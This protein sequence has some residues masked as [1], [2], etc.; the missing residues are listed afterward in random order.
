MSVPT[1]SAPTAAAH[2][3]H[4]APPRLSVPADHLPRLREALQREVGSD[5]AARVLHQVGRDAGA[6]FEARL[7]SRLDASPGELSTDDYFRELSETF[8]EMGWGT[9][10]STRVHPGLCLIETSEWAEGD[11]NAPAREPSCHFT[12]GVFAALLAA[13]A[14][15]PIAVLEVACRTRGDDACAFLFGSEDAIR[16]LHTLLVEGAS[17]AEALERL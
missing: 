10:S 14:T 4:T 12:G 8:E 6:D 11:V 7:R 2:T 15:A 13:L 16:G 1:E 5:V 9:L 17:V 3:S